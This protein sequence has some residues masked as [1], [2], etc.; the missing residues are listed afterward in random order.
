[1]RASK[2]S[3]INPLVLKGRWNQ[4]MKFC[5][6]LKPTQLYVGGSIAVGAF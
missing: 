4:G 6:E 5:E 1:M 3:K 2:N